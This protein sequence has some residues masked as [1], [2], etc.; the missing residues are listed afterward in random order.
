VVLHVLL[1]SVTIVGCPAI[2]ALLDVVFFLL[3]RV[4]FASWIA[5][6]CEFGQWCFVDFLF[7]LHFMQ[8]VLWVL[9]FFSIVA[10]AHTGP[11]ARENR[12]CDRAK[13]EKN[14]QAKMRTCSGEVSTQES[15]RP[16]L[17]PYHSDVLPQIRQTPDSPNIPDSTAK[18]AGKGATV[19]G[20]AADLLVNLALISTTTCDMFS[21]EYS[22]KMCFF[23]D[24]FIPAFFVLAMAAVLVLVAM[25]MS[26]VA[27]ISRGVAGGLSPTSS[28]PST[29][30][31]P[32]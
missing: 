2:A 5:V 23:F 10:A 29:A 27:G 1:L 25:V 6:Y 30:G 20:L 3:L 28:I 22:S 11:P 17:P 13:R 12:F 9:I 4:A 15:L 24:S 26:L 19:R 8:E 31:D 7:Y 14:C 32:D 21:A 18:A 16:V